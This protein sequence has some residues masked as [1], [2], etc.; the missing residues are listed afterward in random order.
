M[1]HLGPLPCSCAVGGSRHRGLLAC[2]APTCPWGTGGSGGQRPRAALTAW[3]GRRP[4]RPLAL[5]QT[6]PGARLVWWTSSTRLT[7]SGY[8]TPA[9]ARHVPC[10]GANVC[11]LLPRTATAVGTKKSRVG[12]LRWDPPHAWPVVAGPPPLP[13]CRCVPT[14]RPG[15]LPGA[16]TLRRPPP[17]RR[18]ARAGTTTASCG[19]P[20]TR[21][22]VPPPPPRVHPSR[23]RAPS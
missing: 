9:R 3:D 11:P 16:P 2:T 21:A 13:P 14:V 5:L 1:Y 17:R 10:G 20:P 15:R 19:G 6:T 4:R 23:L 12:C 7:H 8:D 22:W 18:G